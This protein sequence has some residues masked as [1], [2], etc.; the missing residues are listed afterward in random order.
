MLASGGEQ[1]VNTMPTQVGTPG[2]HHF[3]SDQATSDVFA[4]IPAAGE[5][6]Q[7]LSPAANYPTDPS[8]YSTPSKF[9]LQ[10]PGF[11]S[12]LL[13]SST[14]VPRAEIGVGSP[15]KFISVLAH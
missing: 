13:A 14:V 12:I 10:L 3:P 4:D 8:A 11:S 9:R 5:A 1:P 6:G 7:Q 2:R 15:L